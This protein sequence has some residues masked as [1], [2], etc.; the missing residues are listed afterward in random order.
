[1]ELN[2]LKNS[3][4]NV[5]TATIENYIQK[6]ENMSAEVLLEQIKNDTHRISDIR[7]Q[8]HIICNDI[9]LLQQV[10]DLLT[11]MQFKIA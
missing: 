3:M 8:Y 10:H 1:M 9:I 4:I 5:I 6:Y 2:D 7:S 11:T